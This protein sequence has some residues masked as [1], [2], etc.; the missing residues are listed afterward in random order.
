MKVAPQSRAVERSTLILCVL[1]SLVL[2][3]LPLERKTVVAEVLAH[4]L[5]SPWNRTV[6]FV[7]D[8]AS[9]RAENA[10]LRARLAARDI[11]D[12][13]ADR[14]RRERDE[15]RRSLG[16]HARSPSRLVACEVEQL[17]VDAA[18]T[19]VRVMSTEPVEWRVHQP[20]ITS[21]GLVGRVHQP[22]GDRAAWVEL[23]SS[24]EFA[25]CCEVE[26][27]GLPG[28]LRPGT[29]SFALTLVGRDE[30]VRPGDRLVT[31]DI[32]AVGAAGGALASAMPRGLPVGVVTSVDT[33]LRQIFKAVQ[34]E[35]L[36]DLGALD[37][38]F[39]VTGDGDWLDAGE[40]E[41]P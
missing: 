22:D 9:V 37:V 23:A 35:L 40:E 33:P 6:D 18:T 24:P 30:D 20:V 29:G 15:L 11:G 17:Q 1:V 16:L 31:S 2:L 21:G 12:G 14:L 28:I 38:L 25:L 39:V 3:G 41:T 26:R 32:P 10:D 13:A 4:V 7:S 36:A 5:T 19:L 8:L 27:T 34:V